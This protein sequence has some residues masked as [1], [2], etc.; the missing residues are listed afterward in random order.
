[1]SRKK[2]FNLE[3]LAALTDSRLIG[4]PHHTIF[5]VADLETATSEDAS[6]FANARYAR[7]LQE[8]QAGVIFI[9]SEIPLL[10]GRNYLIV[11]QPSRAFQQVIELLR[12]ARK[13]LSGFQGI[14][15]SAVI[16][17]T[18]RL[19]E[20]VTVAPC[21]VIDEGVVI[22]AGTFIGAGAYIGP[23]VIVGQSCVIHPRVVIREGC[24]LG[25]R[26]IIQ[27]GAVIGSCGFGYTTDREGRHIKLDQ[28]GDVILEENVEIGANTTVDR[29]RFKS[30]RIS[31]GSK[32]DNLV[33]IGHGVSI[34]PHN[35]IVAQTGIAGS[36]STGHHVVLGGQVGMG[37][38]LN[39]GPGA[40]VAAKSGISKSLPGGKKYGGMPAGP[41]EVHNRNQIFLRN[42]ERFV[43]LQKE[44]VERLEK[45]ERSLAREEG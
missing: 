12:P 6:F 23:D 22:G 4:N 10:E 2:C 3:E 1:M 5:D 14:H 9:S 44:L 13:S 29:A 16:H 41:L 33:Q 11:E 8:S 31:V 7:A 30:T 21:A 34:G 15:S 39:I 24:R 37:G 35:M 38:H 27:P 28:V 42:I 40:M 25:N 45:I 43:S 20:G 36:S 17:E 19:E 26:V 18:A 32:I